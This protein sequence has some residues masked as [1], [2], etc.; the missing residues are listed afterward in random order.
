MREHLKLYLL[1]KPLFSRENTIFKY[2][3]RLSLLFFILMSSVFAEEKIVKV[4]GLDIWSETFGK[5]ED[6]VI[7]LIMGSGGQGILWRKEFC[8]KFAKNGFYVIRYDHRDVGE[9]SSCNYEE[10]PYDLMDMTRD[11]VGLLDS[12]QIRKAHLVGA[13]L[14]GC[15]VQLMAVHFPE[16]VHT[17]SLLMTSPDF[18]NFFDALEGKPL[19]NKDLSPPT[20]DYLKWFHSL[21]GQT[22][23]TEE[24]KAELFLNGQEICNGPNIPFSREKCRELILLSLKRQSNPA[25]PLNHMRALRVSLDQIRGIQ[26]QIKV[27]TLIIHG[28]KDPIVPK[29][30]GQALAQSITGAKLLL[31]EGLGHS[32]NFHFE[33]VIIT[34]IIDHCSQ[35]KE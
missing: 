4:N 35:R 22:A 12:L 6:P 31:L 27:P 23:E 13:S 21:A 5:K 30:H 1:R 14:G 19:R 2:F 15:I 3:L 20:E 11:A 29:D 28:T 24:E 26:S 32:L 17:I 9:S 33:D 8:E 34:N 10:Q 7:L 25:T 18:R 16:H